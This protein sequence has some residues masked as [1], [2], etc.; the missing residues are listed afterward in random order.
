MS[1]PDRLGTGLEVAQ[2]AMATARAR[3]V[4]S[5]AA[6]AE[7][8][9]EALHQLRVGLRRLRAAGLTFGPL[10]Q[11]PDPIR[12]KAVA[13]VRRKF[14]AGRDHDVLAALTIRLAADLPA[15]SRQLAEDF[16]ARLHKG[17]R[18]GGRR[19]AQVLKGKRFGALLQALDQWL[20]APH[21]Y[22]TARLP[23]AVTLPDICAPMLAATLLHPGWLVGT[24]E[25]SG[26]L[27]SLGLPSG[28][29]L[30]AILVEEGRAV[31]DL[32]RVV[33]DLRYQS[34]FLHA[35]LGAATPM[36]AQLRDAQE[37]LGGLHDLD[38]LRRR[39]GRFEPGWVATARG[40]DARLKTEER[41]LW[42]A[43]L[44]LRRPLLEPRGRAAFRHALGGEPTAADRR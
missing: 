39:L 23:L 10:L 12:P 18:R 7:G 9:P 43:W 15:S 2:A 29:A 28:R 1:A 30:R 37:V 31:H 16:A 27:H 35:H 24:R 38:T 36:I 26:R 20:S 44:P 21:V 34:E 4:A 13:R 40:F 17:R 8:L 3:I 25:D 33:K 14:G 19:I 41:R 5:T 11:L 22:A 6:A 42:R 32:R